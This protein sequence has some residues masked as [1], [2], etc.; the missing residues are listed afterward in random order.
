MTSV[1]SAAEG[2]AG[3]A[4]RFRRLAFGLFIHYGLISLRDEG[5]GAEWR[6]GEER[7]RQRRFR[8]DLFDPAGIAALCHEAGMRYACLTVRHHDGFSLYDMRGADDYDAPHSGAGRDLV[9]EFVQGMRAAGIV[10]FLYHT[11]L[12][13]R[14]DTERCDERRFEAYLDY[15]HASVEILCTRY[16]EIGGFWFDGDWS[17]PE[18]DWK[19]DRLYR[20]LRR[21][22]PT[23][24]IINNSGVKN[25]GAL[26]HPEIDAVTYENGLPPREA[27]LRSGT[28]AEMC[29]PL[30]TSWVWAPRDFRYLSI[31]QVIE[32]LCT[33]RATGTNLLL[34]TGPDPSGMVPDLDRALLCKIGMWM[35]PLAGILREGLPVAATCE[36][37]DFIL[38]HDGAWFYFAFDVPRTRTQHFFNG[39]GRLGPRRVDGL[40]FTPTWGTWM[41][42]GSPVLIRRVDEGVAFDVEVAGFTGSASGVV[43]VARLERG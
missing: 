2:R 3:R 43:R 15:L 35:R 41:D 28:A 34:N 8:A 33:C 22:Q 19:H 18:A 21:H 7:A 20:M 9:A 24:M 37:R 40:P 32:T 14:W 11:T 31:P 5:D 39:Q 36:D 16:G 23:A 13:R 27:G 10:P 38:E 29:L 42:D 17:R 12:D 6:P 26:V 4:G 1:P 30:N 25:R